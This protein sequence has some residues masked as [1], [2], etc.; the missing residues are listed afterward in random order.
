VQ[1]VVV[2]PPMIE[3]AGQPAAAVQQLA[4]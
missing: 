1:C 3:P 4:S 2:A